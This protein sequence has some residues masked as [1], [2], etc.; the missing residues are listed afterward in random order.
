MG[1]RCLSLPPSSPVHGSIALPA[2]W[3][4]I[5][6]RAEA[7]ATHRPRVHRLEQR[8][9][10]LQFFGGY[11]QAERSHLALCMTKCFVTDLGTVRVWLPVSHAKQNSMMGWLGDCQYAADLPDQEMIIT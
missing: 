2:G 1:A 9:L 10:G 4:G 8:A 5:T 7:W 6:F 11:A 3:Q